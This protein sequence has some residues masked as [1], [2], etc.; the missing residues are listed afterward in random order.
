MYREQYLSNVIKDSEANYYSIFSENDFYG[1]DYIT[2]L[3]HTLKYTN[4]DAITK[5]SYFE[6]NSFFGYIAHNIDQENQEI[7]STGMN[8]NCSLI[9]NESNLSNISNN[10]IILI[11]ICA[12]STCTTYFFIYIL[13]SA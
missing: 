8:S 10:I 11:Y 7:F 5:A 12:F 3:I 4:S 1:I 13:V 9:K 2:N 6:Y